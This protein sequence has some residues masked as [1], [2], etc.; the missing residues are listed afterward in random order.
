M[1]QS[2]PFENIYIYMYIC[3]YILYTIDVV[4]HVCFWGFDTDY[5]DI[6][7]L[8]RTHRSYHIVSRL[9]LAKI[10]DETERTYR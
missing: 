5:S 2:R 7:E 3:T 8:P 4:I 10:E 1:D 6:Q 9:H